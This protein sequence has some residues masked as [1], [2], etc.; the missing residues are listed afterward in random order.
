MAGR[1]LARR[2]IVAYR[3]GGVNAAPTARPALSQHERAPAPGDLPASSARRRR[4]GSALASIRSG[5]TTERPTLRP[6]GGASTI[7]ACRGMNPSG[8]SISVGLL[9]SRRLTA[10]VARQL[11]ESFH[12]PGPRSYC[13]V[14]SLGCFSRPP[15]AL[16]RSVERMRWLT[17]HI[18]STAACGR[19]APLRRPRLRSL[20]SAFSGHCNAAV[21]PSRHTISSTSVDYGLDPA[22]PSAYRPA[23]CYRSGNRGSEAARARYS[24]G[25]SGANDP[26]PSREIG[27]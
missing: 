22:M 12:V 5:R 20:R 27:S 16:I 15:R 2:E 14:R 1:E 24:S 17:D 26:G 23:V 13:R 25:E 21:R 8:L 3:A 9:V 11:T 4:H 7:P 18:S 6:F 10:R 19:L